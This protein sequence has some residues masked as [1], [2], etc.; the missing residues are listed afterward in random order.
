M[1]QALGRAIAA[2][3]GQKALFD[4]PLSR[5]TTW[6]VGGPAWCLCRVHTAH[7]L[8]WLFEAASDSGVPCKIIGRG[9]NLL[10]SDSGFDG[11]IAIMRGKLA[12]IRLGGGGVTCGGGASLP[13]T[14]RR[15]AEYGLGG[16]EWAVGIPCTVG[17]AVA[18]NAGAYDMDMAAVCQKVTLLLP[19]GESKDFGCFELPYG[20]RSRHLPEGAVVLEVRLKLEQET[21]GL[22]ISRRNDFLQ[23]R[24]KAQPVSARTAGSVFKNPEGDYAGRLIEAAGFKGMREGQAVISQKHANFI[25]NMGG[26]TASQIIRL[27]DKT[28]AKIKDDFGITLEPEVEFIGG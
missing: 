23:R 9:S 1:K 5:H 25:E 16:L 10:A 13:R 20:Y 15:C 21:P 22:I 2:K 4:E 12:S 11:I 26:A 6:G 3:L 8:I 28:A 14:V 7:E 24:K 18:G 17:G 27:M 19:G